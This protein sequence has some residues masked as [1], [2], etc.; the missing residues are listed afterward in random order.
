MA[1]AS[2]PLTAS[3]SAQAEPI[4]PGHGGSRGSSA[5]SQGRAAAPG[6]AA[7]AEPGA[8][9]RAG[10]RAVSSRTPGSRGRET[11]HV[12]GST[13]SQSFTAPALGQSR[14]AVCVW[15]LKGIKPGNKGPFQRQML[16]E[17]M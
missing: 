4:A 3:L 10:E 9:E 8:A 6:A 17:V 11:G 5:D 7:D 15:G 12:E 14:G 1:P 13:V 16:R 2:L